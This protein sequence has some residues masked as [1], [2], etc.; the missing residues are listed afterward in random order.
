VVEIAR[1]GL[2]P[3]VR[4]ADDRLGQVFVGEADGFEHR[5]RRSAVPT[6]RDDV[7]QV[8]RIE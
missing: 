6:I 1:H 2:N 7:T 4:D 5:A 8:L 3:H